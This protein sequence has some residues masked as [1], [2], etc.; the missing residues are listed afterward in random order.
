[1]KKT[2]FISIILSLCATAAMAQSAKHTT[3]GPVIIDDPIPTDYYP[4][5]TG[6]ITRSGYTYKYRN[7]KIENTEIPVMIELYNVANPYFDVKR[8]HKDGTPLTYEELMGEIPGSEYV[9]NS[10]QTIAQTLAMVNNCFTAQ[11][12]TMLKDK[13][14]I[15]ELRTDPSTGKVADVYFSFFRNYPFVNIPVETYRSIELALKQNFTVTVTARGRK[16]NYLQ[17]VWEQEF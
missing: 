4:G 2:I 9:S 16:M 3:P 13:T 14:M 5:T 11:Q 6:T 10:S 1:M 12:K 15:I 17:L 8:G 7:A